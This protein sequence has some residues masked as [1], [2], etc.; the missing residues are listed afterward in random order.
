MPNHMVVGSG[1]SGKALVGFYSLL[2]RLRAGEIWGK[3][4]LQACEHRMSRSD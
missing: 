4:V 2:T 1:G 3:E